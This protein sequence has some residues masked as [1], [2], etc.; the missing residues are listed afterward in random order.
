LPAK[1]TAPLQDTLLS[2]I[3]GFHP[4]AISECARRQTSLARKLMRV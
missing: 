3:A 1:W 2:G 4:I